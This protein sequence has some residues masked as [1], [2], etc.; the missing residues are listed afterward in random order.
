MKNRKGDC[1]SG[2]GTFVIINEDGCFVTAGHIFQ[3]LQELQNS[4]DTYTASLVERQKIEDDP[5]MKKHEKMRLLNA[6]RVSPELVTN[7]SIWMGVDTVQLGPVQVIPS[8]D[9]AIGRLLNFNNAGMVRVY[10][11]FKDATK[12]MEPGMSLCKSGFPFHN[13]Q[14]TF[15][16]TTGGFILPPNSV[17]VPLFPLEGIYTRTVQYLEIQQILPL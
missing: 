10:P 2:I 14:P 16:P 9:L 5:L 13:I 8:I 17:P 12:P 4:W 7:F 11:Q 3:Q 6:M 15:D 1:N